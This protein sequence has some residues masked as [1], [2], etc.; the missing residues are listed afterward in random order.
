MVPETPNPQPQDLCRC[1]RIAVPNKKFCQGCLIGA[2]SIANDPIAGEPQGYHPNADMPPFTFLQECHLYPWYNDEGKHV[3]FR[4]YGSDVQQLYALQRWKERLPANELNGRKFAEQLAHY[5]RTREGKFLRDEL[6]KYHILLDGKRI[7]IDA[8]S[9]D[10]KSFLCRAVDITTISRES[11]VAVERLQIAAYESASRMKFRRFSAMYDGPEPRVYVPI[12]SGELLLVRPNSITTVPN[13]DNSD[14]IWLEHPEDAPFEW[15]PPKG[16]DDVRTGLREFQDLIVDKQACKVPEMAW[17][18]AM[19]EAVFPLVRDVTASRFLM[20]HTGPKGHGK[21]TGAKWSVLLHGFEDV[22]LDAS[23]ASL[24]NIPEQGLVVL[25]NKESANFTQPMIDYLL[26]VATGGKRL[27][28]VDGGSRVRRNAPRPVAVIT[29]IEGVHKAELH[30]RCVEVKYYLAKGAPRLKQRK[31][32]R[33]ITDAR[34]RMLSAL[35]VVIQEYL[36]TRVDPAAQRIVTGVNPIDRFSEHFEEVCYLVVAF[37]R[38]LYGARDGDAWAEKLIGVWDAE[39]SE[40]RDEDSNDGAV[41]ALEAPVLAIVQGLGKLPIPFTWQERS[42]RMY[43]VFP[44]DIL[45]ALQHNLA[46]RDLPKEPGGLVKRLMSERLERWTLIR[47]TREH[48]VAD[49]K[50]QDGGQPVG[51]WMPD[52]M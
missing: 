7:P 15:Q 22:L 5:I 48:P 23:V 45:E 34:H 50:R 40:S 37:G 24:G 52:P 27:R 12:A 10:M 9:D 3:G 46:L 16:I 44:G 26:S 4:C 18:V 30:D 39:I 38:M 1:G 47:N 35:A 6:G 19:T 31:I 43:I 51:V 13:A 33:T 28:C 32:E 2:D 49:L 14:Q 17:F 36:T 25:D 11:A 41:S 20:L 42:G 21:T 8:T 29:S